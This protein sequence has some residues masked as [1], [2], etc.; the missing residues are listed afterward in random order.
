MFDFEEKIELI[1]IGNSLFLGALDDFQSLNLTTAS[2]RFFLLSLV[3]CKS[4]LMF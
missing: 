3:A 2:Q 1:L 4:L